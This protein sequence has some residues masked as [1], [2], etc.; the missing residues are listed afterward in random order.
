M[1]LQHA[2][3]DMEFDLNV[4]IYI[5]QTTKQDTYQ[6]ILTTTLS[7]ETKSQFQEEGPMFPVEW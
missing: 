1:R 4:T 5:L 3:N 7:Q 6:K 2:D